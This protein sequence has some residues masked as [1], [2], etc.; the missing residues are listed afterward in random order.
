MFMLGVFVFFFYI[1]L[2]ATHYCSVSAIFIFEY[3]HLVNSVFLLIEEFEH[4]LSIIMTLWLKFL[5]RAGPGS[6]LSSITLEN[7]V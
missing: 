3:H 1:S 7:S 5:I 2:E 4:A 6:E